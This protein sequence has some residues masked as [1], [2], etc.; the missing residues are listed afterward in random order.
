[1][2]THLHTH[3]HYSLLDGLIKIDDLV[4]M[5][6]KNGM[7][8]LALTDHG[9]MYGVIEFYQKAL[10]VGVKPLIGVEVYLANNG[11][12]DKRPNIDNKQYHLVLIA[13]NKQ[14]YQNLIK[15]TTRAHL[16]G[17]YYKPRIDREL[18]KKHKGGLVALSACLKGEI[19]NAIMNGDFK[20][21]E[22][23]ALL[24]QNTFG[25]GNFYL[26]LQH[27]PNIPE[28]AKVNAEL[29]KISK[30]HNIPLVAT[31]DIHYL[32]KTDAEA[33]E[34]LLCLQS[35]NTLLDQNRPLSMIG[36]DFS[37]TPPKLMEEYFRDIPEALENTAK[38]AKMCNLNISLGQ[39]KLPH[40][41]VP[42]GTT[43]TSYL[44]RLCLL[45]LQKRYQT[46]YQK[47]PAAI[48]ERLNYELSIIEKTGFATYF[49]IV[50]DFVNWAK[51]HN[52]V[53]GPGRGSAAG[54]LVSYL[55]NI[56]D[57][58]PITHELLFERFL[59]PERI[60]MPDIDLDF[61]DTR[62]DEVITYVRQKYGQDHVAQIITFGT[63]AA[64][65]AIRDV[66][67][68]L[69]YPYSFC[70]QIA[71]MIPMFFSLERAF[72]TIP[73]LK[74][75]YQQ[76]E[77]VKKLIDTA[78][79]LEGVARHASTHAC[80]V[81]ITKDPIDEVAPRQYASASD[82]TIVSQYEMH[83]IE[84]TGLLKMDFLG[85]K[86]LTILENTL[87]IIEKIRSDKVDLKKIPMDDPQT[88]KLLAQGKTTGVFQLESSGMKRYLKELQP[89]TFEDIVAMVSLYRP[90]PMEW[91]PDY[92]AGKNEKEKITYLHPK[93]KPIL[94]KT[95]G[96]AVYQEQVLQIARDLA[97]FSLGEADILRKAVG[98]KIPKLLAE[99]KEKFIQGCRQ[100]GLSQNLAEK[101]FSFIEP[102]AGYGFNR[103]HAA[104][105]ALIGYQTAYLKTHYPAEFMAAL[106]T[107]D[108][109]DTDRIAIEVDECLSLGI[110]VLPPDI[111]ESFANF[112]VV[113]QEDKIENTVSKE[114]IRFGLSAIKNVGANIVAEIIK[115]RKQNDPYQ[116]LDDF[117]KRVQDKDLNKKS[118]E[119]LVKCGALDKFGER[120]QILA[121]IDKILHYAREYR[122]INAIG[123]R[124]LFGNLSTTQ[125]NLSRLRLGEVATASKE[126]KLTWEKDLL[127]LYISHHPLEDYRECLA[128]KT[129]PIH[130]LNPLQK[131]DFVTL[132]GIIT[133]IKKIITRKGDPMLFVTLEDLS[134]KIEILVFP[135]L[136]A[137]N[138]TLWQENKVVLI[139]GKIS[140]KDGELKLLAD[141]ASHITKEIL[142]EFQQKVKGQKI[143]PDS[144]FVAKPECPKVQI[145]LPRATDRD[146]LIKLKQF[147]ASHPGSCP[148][149][150]SIPNGN[151]S[152]P[153]QI[154][155]EF[156][157]DLQQNLTQELKNFLGEKNV[158]VIGN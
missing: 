125:A 13:K 97:G 87:K 23:S 69:S 77:K 147:L 131:N 49:L 81:L 30:K 109:S 51:N 83:A 92:I 86:N 28:Q 155:T 126:E 40:Y 117:I 71:K 66:G 3:S 116:N 121:N 58:D 90:G 46:N 6:S 137:Q 41:Q 79:K 80:G 43:P 73:E 157:V 53:V 153:E 88:F 67:R 55:L 37:F 136:L 65:A 140:D 107:S 143:H 112:T 10:S 84:S 149:Y 56:T 57:I 21:A 14:G 106:L 142:M 129:T 82:Q 98:K 22:E 32:E 152:S 12:M 36:E 76:D 104:C 52:I 145:Q 64:R 29:I 134:D 113:R 95:Y 100:N 72:S 16:E 78:R 99:Q 148:V 31:N 130:A 47:A 118:L 24:Y 123:Q 96:V 144:V 48:V 91:I 15:L 133:K 4:Q 61:A 74:T 138:P 75:A 38:V 127:G 33:Q 19:P 50:Q 114:V 93:L 1:M 150:L 42:S 101:I 124:D 18:L 115:E 146:L 44:K 151:P 17:F 119:S 102:F 139:S 34:I 156:K 141:S 39:T 158:S 45:G 154:K 63:M 94:E 11:M 9:V 2:F 5:A 26:E 122:R 111:N 108:Q 70:D 132:G 60:S 110:K 54:S 89:T 8:A 85:L 120:N 62:R 35:K 105:Y 20:K 103:A 128:Y 7:E 25:A 68:V 27:H 135:R 59:N